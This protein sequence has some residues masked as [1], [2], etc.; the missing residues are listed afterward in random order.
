VIDPDLQDLPGLLEWGD[1]LREATGRAEEQRDG[2]R[3]RRRP[4]VRRLGIALAGMF[5]LVPGAVATRSIWDEPVQRVAP[6]APT[7]STPAVRL[8]EGQSNGVAWRVGGYDAPQGR[9]CL[10]LEVIG[11]ARSR[12]IRGCAPPLTRAAITLLT[13]A[14]RR[15]G[16]VYGTVAVGAR[17][18]EVVVSDGRRVRV[19][20]AG[21]SAETLRRSG[22][23]GAFRV[24]VAPFDGGLPTA[25]Q[26]QVTAY[27]AGGRELG[28]VGAR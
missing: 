26:P 17:S 12:G 4:P 16:F 7:P 3:R 28:S 27:D 5:L 22:M 15:A 25:R 24:F 10:Q 2:A 21:I 6:L 9:R 23:R 13:A 19:G 18:V 14:G 1:E 20:T 8:A 11:G